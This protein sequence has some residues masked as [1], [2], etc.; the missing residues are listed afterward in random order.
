MQRDLGMLHFAHLHKNVRTVWFSHRELAVEQGSEAR[1]KN[2]GC[3]MPGSELAWPVLRQCCSHVFVQVTP[4][5]ASVEL[6]HVYVHVLLHVL[7]SKKCTGH[8]SA[9]AAEIV[10]S[11]PNLLAATLAHAGTCATDIWLTAAAGA[12]F[13]C[14]FVEI[15]YW[16]AEFDCKMVYP[17]TAITT[18]TNNEGHKCYNLLTNIVRNKIALHFCATC[19]HSTK[20]C[21]LVCIKLNIVAQATRK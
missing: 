15:G 3:T 2:S 19:V 6:L 1:M 10:C 7:V 16:N 17:P 14:S 12:E 18:C 4:W 8:R 20:L 21:N 11:L 13:E 5:P 9:A